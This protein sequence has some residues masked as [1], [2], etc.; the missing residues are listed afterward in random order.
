M[1]FDTTFLSI[2][3]LC[4]IF[5]LLMVLKDGNQP[6]K[7]A[8]KKLLMALLP[9]CGFAFWIFTHANDDAGPVAGI[10]IMLF[11]LAAPFL[12]LFM[13]VWVP[14]RLLNGLFRKRK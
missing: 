1:D 5:G 13:L 10:A 9:V 7:P 2:P 12:L 8:D 4:L 6:A 3:A 14:Y 11:T